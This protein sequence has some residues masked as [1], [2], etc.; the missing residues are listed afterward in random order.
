MMRP[1]IVDTDIVVA[2]LL[3]VQPASPVVRILDA[4]LTGQFPFVVSEAL[5]AEYRDVLARPRLCK[6]HGLDAAARETLLVELAQHAI[7]L[8]PVAAV[9]APAPGDQHLWN[10]LAARDDLRLVTGDK[11]L[12]EDSAMRPRLLTAEALVASWSAGAAAR[13]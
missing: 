3:T 6:A 7:V 5:L 9:A 2:G 4:M 8:Q 12:L 10:L 11:R 1:T 13:E